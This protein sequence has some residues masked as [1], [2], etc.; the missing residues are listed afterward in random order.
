MG[1]DS[2]TVLRQILGESAVLGVVAALAGIAVGALLAWAISA[3]GI[4]MPPP[5]NSEK[6]YTAAIRLS[7]ENLA[8]AALTGVVACVAG[9]ILPA[10]RLSRMPI[11]DA[12]R[13][14]V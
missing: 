14:G 8:L 9:A 2:G 1:Y 3:V 6:V 13:R 11:V 4:D 10:R 5:P 7:G 12:L